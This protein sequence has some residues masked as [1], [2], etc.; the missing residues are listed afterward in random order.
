MEIARTR[1]AVVEMNGEGGE[2]VT[3]FRWFLAAM[4][5]P[6]YLDGDSGTDNDAVNPFSGEYLVIAPRACTR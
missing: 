6:G 2:D 3:H 1:S 4:V 5:K